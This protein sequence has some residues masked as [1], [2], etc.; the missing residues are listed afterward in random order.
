MRSRRNAGVPILSWAVPLAALAVILLIWTDETVPV[1]LLGGVAVATFALGVLV[2]VARRPGAERGDGVPDLSLAPALVGFALAAMLVGAE[3]G[4]WL[5]W[6]GG[7]MLAL[8][9]AGV[10]RERLRQRKPE[11]SKPRRPRP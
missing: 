8:G 2:A 10:L 1:L 5:V 6:V 3:G 4:L 7:G 9:L 11:S